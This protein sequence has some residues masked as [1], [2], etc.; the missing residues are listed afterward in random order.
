[1][2]VVRAVG[3]E[4]ETAYPFGVVRRLFEPTVYGLEPAARG[5][6][7]VPALAVGSTCTCAFVS[8]RRRSKQFRAA[9]GR[10]SEV[11]AG[12]GLQG[13]ACVRHVGLAGLPPLFIASVTAALRRCEN[14]P[15]R[16]AGDRRVLTLVCGAITDG[17]G[18]LRSRG[19]SGL[20]HNLAVLRSRPLRP[21]AV[22]YWARTMRSPMGELA[23]AGHARHAPQEMRPLA[24]DVL[25]ELAQAQAPASL[26]EL[27]S[28]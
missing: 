8:S 25:G 2:R 26:Q 21:V 28:G 7:L 15:R 24:A 9:A 1:M 10:A 19:V 20:S 17:F 5:R 12:S 4:L 16:L 18:A 3:L 13:A 11:V 14:D 23:F 22:C 6:S 27:L